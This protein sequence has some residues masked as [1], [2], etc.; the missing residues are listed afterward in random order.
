[1]A[2]GYYLRR[3]HPYD[4][5]RYLAYHENQ[6]EID[7]SDISRLRAVNGAGKDIGGCLSRC[8]RILRRDPDRIPVVILIGDGL[9]V[10]G[11][12]AGIY[13]FKENNRTVIESAYHQARMLSKEHINFIFLQFAE[14]RH[15]WEDLADETAGRVV[16]EARG[17]RH[18]ISSSDDVGRALLESSRR[19][20]SQHPPAKRVP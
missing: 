3:Y 12:Q 14:E 13:R 15:F 5:V 2:F 11:D 16:H 19:I 7:F 9:P 4:R 18:R 20:R 1:M 10:R 17:L 6:R 8:R